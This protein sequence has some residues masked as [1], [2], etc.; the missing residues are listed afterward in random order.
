MSNTKSS[1]ATGVVASGGRV[2]QMLERISPAAKDRAAKFLARLHVRAYRL[3]GGS[4]VGSRGTPSLLLTTTG[5]RSGQVRT[6]ALFYLPDGTRQVLVAS[7][8]GDDRH[9]QWYLNLLANPAVTVQVGR[10][11]WRA[12][13]T[14]L[15][16][17]DR[18]SI[19]P[20]L[21][22]NYPGYADYQQRTTRELP[23]VALTPAAH[24]V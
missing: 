13:A 11:V 7:Y 1:K 9:P 10:D 3:T 12:T 18:E 2:L 6:T 14:T 17:D 24:A 23:V 15:T 8:A 16:D 22:Q 21:V 5:R 20:R 4:Q 19:W